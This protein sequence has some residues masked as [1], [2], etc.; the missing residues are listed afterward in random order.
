MNIPIPR[1]HPDERYKRRLALR[2]PM[3]LWHRKCMKEGCQNEFETTYA[4]GRPEVVYCEDCYKH[5]IY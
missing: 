5:E 2:N 3:K 1:L 4:H